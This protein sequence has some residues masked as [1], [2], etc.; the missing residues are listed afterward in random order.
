MLSRMGTTRTS[1]RFVVG[2]ALITTGIAGD[3]AC[4]KQTVNTRPPDINT[5]GDRN[6][7]NDPPQ[8]PPP[9]PQPVADPQ[10]ED[11]PPP[12]QQPIVNTR[13]EDAPPE[14][15]GP[16][17]VNIRTADPPAKKK[18][19]RAPKGDPNPPRVNTVPTE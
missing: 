16:S 14:D 2:T 5:F 8:D 18:A 3:A 7:N 4:G 11:G 9:D 10:P 1:L 19:P 6:P 17:T 12:D 13:P 15:I